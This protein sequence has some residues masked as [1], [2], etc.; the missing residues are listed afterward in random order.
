MTTAQSFVVNPDFRVEHFDD[1]IL[2]YAITSSTGMYLNQTAYLVW[3]LCRD[4]YS[5]KEII[6]LLQEKY[7]QRQESIPEDVH[8][9]LAS[10]LESGAILTADE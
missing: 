5:G 8:N 1:E 9:T 4:G 10:L 2:L 6:D 7:P 3:R